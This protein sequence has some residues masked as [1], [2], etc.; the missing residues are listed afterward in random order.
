MHSWGKHNRRRSLRSAVTLCYK[1]ISVSGLNIDRASLPH[2]EKFDRL[3]GCFEDLGEAMVAYSGG[4]DSTLLLKAGTLALGHACIG[5]IAR[6]ETLTDDEYEAAQ[7]VAA[8]H[9]FNLEVITYSELA[10]DGY[11]ANPTNRCYFCKHELYSRVSELARKR[12]VGAIAEGSNADDIGDWRPGL[13]AVRELN[14][15]SPLREA[16]LH[17]DEIRA[18]ARALGLANWNKPSNPCLSSRIAYGERIDERKLDQV[19]RGEKLLRARGFRQ[20]RV[21]HLGV[22]A[23]IEVGT[24]E[25]ERLADPRLRKAV[26]E[27]IAALGFKTVE[28]DPRGYRSG[29]MNEAFHNPPTRAGKDR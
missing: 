25:I 13:R 7:A 17:K 19:A 23:R 18:L 29:S 26:S 1:G 11:A 21:R 22:G 6:S 20:V 5:V 12:G 10:I 3:I 24:D 2:R 4:V 16:D 9:G 27:E 8:E 15:I 28:I 14:V